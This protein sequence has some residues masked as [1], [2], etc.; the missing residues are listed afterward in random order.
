SKG[1][2]TSHACL[3][4]WR[5]NR[6]RP[7]G[8]GTCRSVRP[9]LGVPMSF[10]SLPLP[11]NLASLLLAIA[12]V[13]TILPPGYPAYIGSYVTLVSGVVASLVFGWRERTALLHPT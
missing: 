7:R 11:F 6:S 2:C 1:G 10:R 12:V 5:R 8:N 9:G 13:A 3:A 4:L